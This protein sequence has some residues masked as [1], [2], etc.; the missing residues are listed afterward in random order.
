MRLNK[1]AYA[2]GQKLENV[3]NGNRWVIY[4][5]RYDH[6]QKQW[7]YCMIRLGEENPIIIGK[8]NNEKDFLYHE[9]LKGKVLRNK[10]KLI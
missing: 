5:T 10:L 8:G 9:V 3:D 6:E 7:R 4:F 1:D 2:L